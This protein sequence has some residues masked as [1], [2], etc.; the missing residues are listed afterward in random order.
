MNT[1]D[2][3]EYKQ[4]SEEIRSLIENKEYSEA[5]LIA[6]TID[7]S[8]VKNVTML[9]MVSDLYKIN[10]KYDVS[11]DL[12]LLAYERYPGGRTII[13]S[14]CELSIKMD[15][16][17][18][19]VEYYKE[20]VQIAPKDTG[21]Y[22]LQYKLYEAQNVGLEERIQVLEE[23]KRHERREKWC[24]EL[25][26]L[27]HRIGLA[28][29]CVEECDE[30][31]LWFGTGKYVTKA[32][33]LKMLHEPLTSSQ[34]E[35]YRN[36]NRV[37]GAAQNE[38][39]PVA[40]E[41]PS[42]K[43]VLSQDTKTIP[44]KDVNFNVKTYDA[45]SQ[46]N[47]IDIQKEIAASMHDLMK[48]SKQTSMNAISDVDTSNENQQEVNDAPTFDTIERQVITEFMKDEQPPVV[49]PDGDM[50]EL[51]FDENNNYYEL[52]KDKSQRA[53]SI[54]SN[55]EEP[56]IQEEVPKEFADKLTQEYDG[57]ISLVVPESE[58]I[59]KQITGQLNFEDILAEWE[60]MKH[61][62]E[63]KRAE[64][65]QIRVKQSTE[66]VLSQFDMEKRNTTLADMEA[67]ADAHIAQDQ[68][69]DQV[70]DSAIETEFGQQQ[71]IEDID[72]ETVEGIAILQ[73]LKDEDIAVQDSYEELSE[74]VDNEDTDEVEELSEIEESVE[75]DEPVETD[76]LAETEELVD[77]EELEE[78]EESEDTEE[79]DVDDEIEDSEETEESNEYPKEESRDNDKLENQRDENENEE[80]QRVATRELTSYEAELFGAVVE[81]EKVKNQITK[82][83]DQI[84]IASYTGNVIITGEHGSR[85]FTLAKNLIRSVQQTDSN[86]SGK[87]AKVSGSTL[88]HKDVTATFDKLQNGAIIIEKAGELSEET[89]RQMSKYI[90]RENTGIIV[91]LEDTKHAIQKLMKANSHIAESFTARVD[92]AEMDNKSLVRYGKR[93]AYEKEYSIDEFAVLALHT[94]IAD[95]QTGEH[96]VTLSEVRDII[97]EAI[98]SAN[99]KNLKH[100]FDIIF[101]KRYDKEDMIILKEKDFIC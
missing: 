78:I 39:S 80:N 42:A 48:D 52:V 18:Q 51:I 95:M 21:R 75:T 72:P 91:V 97:D 60:R 79:S 77:T 66:D 12:L 61:N 98:W 96:Q 63:E 46:F 22:I 41:I 11:R 47:T 1:L 3:Y 35:K 19:A 34:E 93:Y 30:I 37:M 68:D 101:A 14:L 45:N 28:T 31:A 49:K 20:F 94:R 2:K 65:I 32:L 24:Y 9:T 17:V 99:R 16:F 5:M 59:E 100:F 64:E 84:S 6:D 71:L 38:N 92:I 55:A 54:V 90:D 85:T 82:A 13:Y 40:S 7:W 67:V 87:V 43:E 4:R 36:R 81:T 88:N 26:F 27:Y 8:R 33:E 89:L 74:E 86:F 15:D 70:E 62:L 57:Q 50:Q 53:S 23:F 29:K 83:L 76:E 25:A 56:I 10:K 44:V 69:Q 73:G 58:M